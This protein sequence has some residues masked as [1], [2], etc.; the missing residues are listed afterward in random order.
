VRKM[1]LGCDT[2]AY[3]K[4]GAG[5]GLLESEPGLTVPIS[6]QLNKRRILQVT[7]KRLRRQVREYRLT[8]GV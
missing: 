2:P 7:Y 6:L 5:Y 8:E 4:G 3:E 1:V